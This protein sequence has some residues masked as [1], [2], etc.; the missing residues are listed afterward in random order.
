M[1]S[2]G[3][4]QRVSVLVA[5]SNVLESFAD[6]Q[7][8]RFLLLIFTNSPANVVV[9]GFGPTVAGG[10]TA[11]PAPVRLGPGRQRGRAL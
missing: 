1:G 6:E 5:I 9:S 7:W 10:S 8:E 4:N 3:Q 11:C 2:G